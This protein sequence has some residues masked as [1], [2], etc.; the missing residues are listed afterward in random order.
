MTNTPERF[1]IGQTHAC[2]EPKTGL[3]H[4]IDCSPGKVARAQRKATS[5]LLRR[6]MDLSVI[7]EQLQADWEAQEELRKAQ[8]AEW[9]EYNEW[10]QQYALDYWYDE[11]W[12]DER[13]ALSD[14]PHSMTDE[15]WEEVERY[16]QERRGA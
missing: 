14:E 13:T 2:H 6:R 12:E 9:A 7:E 16:Y 8:E 5:N 11:R 10:Y 3:V 15:E 1:I 4:R